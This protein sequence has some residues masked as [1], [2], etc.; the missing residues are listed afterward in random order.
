MTVVDLIKGIRNWVNDKID[1]IEVG[2]STIDKE[3]SDLTI[4]DVIDILNSS[5]SDGGDEIT[6]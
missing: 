4:E 1:G 5:D 2:E 6:S 3:F